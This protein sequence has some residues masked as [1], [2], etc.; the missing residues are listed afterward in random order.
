MSYHQP[1]LTWES[2]LNSACTPH[3]SDSCYHDLKCGH[4]IQTP[5][6]E[7]CGRNCT[8]RGFYHPCLLDRPFLCQV[9]YIAELSKQLAAEGG[10]VRD[11]NS[12]EVMDY[13]ATKAQRIKKRAEE[14][15]QMYLKHGARVCEKAPKME[16]PRVQIFAEMEEEIT[17]ARKQSE[18]NF[19][20]PN[21][22]DPQPV[23]RVRDRREL[24]EMRIN[25][26]RARSMSPTRDERSHRRGGI[27]G[28]SGRKHGKGDSNR[29]RG[30]TKKVEDGRINDLAGHLRDTK[31]GLEKE[32]AVEKAVRELFP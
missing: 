18:R 8:K 1:G 9:C 31:V 26:A 5:Y 7:G 32:S 15:I 17:E 10:G 28:R 24:W 25:R 23:V 13:E 3:T 19:K 22:K 16:D 4:R 6:P 30:R 12:E 21:V 11:E 2:W 27:G 20:R 29:Q 14:G